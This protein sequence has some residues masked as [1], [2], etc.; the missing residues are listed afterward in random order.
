MTSRERELAYIAAAE[1]LRLAV[2]FHLAATREKKPTDDLVV[3]RAAVVAAVL[4][5]EEASL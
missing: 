3:S 2:R 4:K 1:E 5:M